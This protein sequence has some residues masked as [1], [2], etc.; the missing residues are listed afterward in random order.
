MTS[1]AEGFIGF[2]R[3]ARSGVS[4]RLNPGSH[5]ATVDPDMMGRIPPIRQPF[6][7]PLA[8]DVRRDM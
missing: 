5:L 3:L 1:D 6:V 4:C 8:H 7:Q 2:Q